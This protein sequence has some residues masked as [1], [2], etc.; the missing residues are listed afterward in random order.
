MLGHAPLL[1]FF[2]VA[3]IALPFLWLCSAIAWAIRF[4]QHTG[5]NLYAGMLHVARARADRRSSC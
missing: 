1:A 3:D 5:D 4:S 2:F